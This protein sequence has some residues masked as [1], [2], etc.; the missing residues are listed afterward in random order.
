MLG[1]LGQRHLKHPYHQSQTEKE[2][3]TLP[4]TDV[5]QPVLGLSLPV[6]FAFGCFFCAFAHTLPPLWLESTCYV[7]SWILFCT[8][9]CLF[10]RRGF[11]HSLHTRRFV[12]CCLRPPSPLPS[13]PLRA[14]CLCPPHLLRSFSLS[15]LWQ[16]SRS[17]FPRRLPWWPWSGI[18]PLFTCPSVT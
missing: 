12:G 15:L 14:P 2:H 7:L 17:L 4:E 10:F 16:L 3:L 11:P 1:C 13:P 8:P 9:I 18:P 6:P 5:R